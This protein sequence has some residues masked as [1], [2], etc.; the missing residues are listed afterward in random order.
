MIQLTG[1]GYG[2]QI[3]GVYCEIIAVSVLKYHLLTCVTVDTQCE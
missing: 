3:K 1:G 2:K